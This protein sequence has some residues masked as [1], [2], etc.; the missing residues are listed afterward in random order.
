MSDELK[1]WIGI[2]FWVLIATGIVWLVYGIG[3]AF[4]FSFFVLG[5]VAVCFMAWYVIRWLRWKG[6]PP[7]LID[8][9]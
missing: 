9:E 2:V 5:A 6:V 1:P 8:F 3:A 7:D 4:G